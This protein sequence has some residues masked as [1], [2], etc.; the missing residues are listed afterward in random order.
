[1][2]LVELETKD[3][4]ESNTSASYLD[5]LLSIGRDGQL[6]TSIYDKR[7]DFNFHTTNFP[8]LSSNI[9]TSPAYG[10]FILQLIR[11]ARACSSYG[12]F[13][14]RATRLSNKLLEQGYVKER[15]KSSLRKFYCRYGDLIKQ[16]EVSLSQMLNDILWPD[17]TQWQ[18]PTDQTLYRT[19][20]S[21]IWV[22][23][24]EH[25]RR[26]WHADRG[27]LLL[28]TPCPVPLGLAYVLLVETNPFPNLSLFYRTMLFEYPSV[29]S[30]FCPLANLRT[31]CSSCGPFDVILLWHYDC[32]AIWRA[33]R[34]W[35][36]N[37]K[38]CQ[39]VRCRTF[40]ETVLRLTLDFKSFHI[41]INR[42][43]LIK[44]C[45]TLFIKD[46]QKIIWKRKRVPFFGKKY[47]LNINVHSFYLDII[48]FEVRLQKYP[49]IMAK[50]LKCCSLW[51]IFWK[52]HGGGGGGGGGGSSNRIALM[53]HIV[54]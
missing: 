18:P 12:C 51:C 21:E 19:R 37:E 7:D 33:I 38:V 24:I 4:T 3:T 40:G 36:H 1:M 11:Y 13:I 27:R 22:V 20:P 47:W 9:P 52:F 50:I 6:H 32:A 43:C 31:C 49:L 30:R 28:R 10:V 39:Q 53:V 44:R 42:R 45:N 16:Y 8:F 17:H 5:L 2:Y 46:W 25:L 35:R 48:N 54:N 14:L 26:V 29:L 34:L 23:S 41:F 15:L